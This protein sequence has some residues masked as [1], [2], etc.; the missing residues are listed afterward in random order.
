MLKSDEKKVIIEAFKA[1]VNSILTHS[2]VKLFSPN[3]KSSKNPTNELQTHIMSLLTS[4][5]DHTVFKS[6]SLMFY[7]YIFAQLFLIGY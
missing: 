3:Q 2:L 5:L 1:I 4:L 6:M 7:Y